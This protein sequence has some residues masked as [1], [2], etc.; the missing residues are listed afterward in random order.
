MV[1]NRIIQQS[2]R[3]QSSTILQFFHDESRAAKALIELSQGT[4]G[5]HLAPRTRQVF[6]KL[7]PLLLDWLS[8]SADPDA[9]LNHFV[10]IRI[11]GF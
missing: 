5:F 4:S 1:F 9:T 2:G 7:K 6:R 10:R 8:K 3:E 11:G